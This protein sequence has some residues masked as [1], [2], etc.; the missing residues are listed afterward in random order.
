VG[1]RGNYLC[2]ALIFLLF[3]ADLAGD[4]GHNPCEDYVLPPVLNEQEP[5]AICEFMYRCVSK[6]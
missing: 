5:K 2:D 4:R 1:D 3:L 6:H